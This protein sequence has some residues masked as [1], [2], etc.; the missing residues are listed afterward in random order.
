MPA[1]Q[2]KRGTSFARSRNNPT[3]KWI[4]LFGRNEPRRSH[5]DADAHPREWVILECVL[6]TSFTAY[7]A[8]MAGS[9][10]AARR[11]ARATGVGLGFVSVFSG[12]GCAGWARSGAFAIW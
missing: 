7:P 5:D 1:F 9:R 8:R 3:Q 11:S 10:D 6:V 12:S 2:L 4:C